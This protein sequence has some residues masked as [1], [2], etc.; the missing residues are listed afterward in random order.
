MDGSSS[1]E[2]YEAKEIC[3]ETQMREMLDRYITVRE[4]CK[5]A[6]NAC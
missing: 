1:D 3:A 2:D 4:R 5:S 6:Q